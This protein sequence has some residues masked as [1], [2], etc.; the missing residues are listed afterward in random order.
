MIAITRVRLATSA[1]VALLLSTPGVSHA[2]HTPDPASVGVPGSFQSEL[3]CPGDWQPECA[4]THLA[5][6]AGDAVWQG[7]WMIP[8]GN[9]EY[10][11]ALN[12]SWTENY[13]LH[14][15]PGG[16]NITL[17]LAAARPVKFYYDHTTHWITDN[18]SS[19][20]VTAPGNYQSELGCP[21]DWQPDCLRSWLQD[22]DGDGTFTRTV[23][24]LA[25][26]SYEVKAAIDESW[27]EN[28]GQD[29]LPDGPN[30]AFTVPSELSTV[31]FSYNDISHVLTVTVTGPTPTAARS[32][33][34]L[35]I[36]YR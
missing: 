21:G 25:V 32:W 12:D 1:L 20:I 36:T 10:K 16:P 26:G 8:A 5:F 24:G 31:N 18:V 11:A 6:D 19:R 2:D 30:I 23:T 9:W 14:A 4:V 33:G 15:T 28:Y 34:R 3:G 17:S 7:T 29:G 22:P 27:A 35:K 13:G